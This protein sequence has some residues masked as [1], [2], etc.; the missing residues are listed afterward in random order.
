[1]T[2]LDNVKET[3]DK[4]GIEYYVRDDGTDDMI[5]LFFGIETGDNYYE[6]DQLILN[7]AVYWTFEQNGTQDSW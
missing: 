4:V 1:M 5:F 2:D 6:T 3:F 7:D